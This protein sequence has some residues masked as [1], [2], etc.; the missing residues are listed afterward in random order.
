MTPFG[1]MLEYA[2]CGAYEIATVDAVKLYQTDGIPFYNP[3]YLGQLYDS[4][5]VV[6]VQSHAFHYC[7][8]VFGSDTSHPHL[9]TLLVATVYAPKDS[10]GVPIMDKQFIVE[11]C[12]FPLLEDHKIRIAKW[13][14]E[15]YPIE[16]ARVF[17]ACANEL[18]VIRTGD[19]NTFKDKTETYAQQMHY[20]TNGFDIVS[21][22]PVSYEDETIRLYGTF[23]PFPHDIVPGITIEK[24]TVDSKNTSV[25]DYM[26]LSKSSKYIVPGKCRLMVQPYDTVPLT[27]HLPMF[28][29][30]KL[31]TVGK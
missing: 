27:D 15:E 16:R 28:V 2:T 30:F 25:L 8:D 17:G 20:L 7:K 24:P 22:S 11:S 10:K 4:Q 3:F 13:L 29:G 23:Y 26:F 31:L 19:F 14:D 5:K 12:H 9:G 1:I 6:K 18:P 21:G